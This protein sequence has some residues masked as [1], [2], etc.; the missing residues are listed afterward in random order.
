MLTTKSNSCSTSWALTVSAIALATLV[1]LSPLQNAA[2]A[3]EGDATQS[4]VPGQIEFSGALPVAGANAGSSD[5]APA[6]GNVQGVQGVTFALFAEQTG[7]TALWIESQNVLL[8]SGGDAAG[9]GMGSYSVLLGAATV[10]G[11]PQELF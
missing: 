3:A 7:G 5:G 11:I 9:N 8:T 6:Q 1:S 4:S 2:Q 10:G